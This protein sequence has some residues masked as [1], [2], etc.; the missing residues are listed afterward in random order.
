MV[1]L[2]DK[3]EQELE[4]EISVVYRIGPET[5]P[6]QLSSRYPGA[7]FPDRT[8]EHRVPC[9]HLGASPARLKSQEQRPCFSASVF[10]HPER[11]DSIPRGEFA[12]LR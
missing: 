12:I 9:R 10:K 8:S 7:L 4:C 6:A 2:I 11:K 1:L 3:A 5:G